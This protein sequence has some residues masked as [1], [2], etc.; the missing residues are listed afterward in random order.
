MIIKIKKLGNN[1]LAEK[2]V[3]KIPNLTE[4]WAEPLTYYSLKD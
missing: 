2:I 1:V 3:Y 4:I